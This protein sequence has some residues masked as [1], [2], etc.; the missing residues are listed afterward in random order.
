MVINMKIF[1]LS[2]FNL[3][4]NRREAFAIVPLTLITV[5]LL[6]TVAANIA[7]AGTVFEDTKWDISSYQTGT[8]GAHGAF[9]LWESITDNI[10]PLAPKL[11]DI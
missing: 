5:F 10:K 2:L 1:R 7:K 11:G 6:G 8:V 3:R 4:K 9:Y